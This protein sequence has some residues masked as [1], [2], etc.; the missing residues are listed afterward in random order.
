MNIRTISLRRAWLP[1][2]ATLLLLQIASGVVTAQETSASSLAPQE[3]G[4]IVVQN[5]R[6]QCGVTL[7]NCERKRERG[8]HCTREAQSC[9][10]NCQVSQSRPANSS[11]EDQESICS[12]RCE[13]SASLCDKNAIQTGEACLLGRAAC[14][15]RCA[16]KA[17]A[18]R[19]R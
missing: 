12:Q 13:T 7:A 14:R 4:Q 15:D 18:A 1:A 11:I 8:L 2:A 9:R 5:C 3:A 17:K 6:M 19:A 10:D 16:T